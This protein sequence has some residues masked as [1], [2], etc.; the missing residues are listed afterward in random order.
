MFNKPIIEHYFSFNLIIKDLHAYSDT[1]WK[2]NGY[3][4]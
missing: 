1:T 2:I 4:P 3:Y